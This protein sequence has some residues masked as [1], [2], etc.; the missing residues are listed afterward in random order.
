[1]IAYN[2]PSLCIVA[3]LLLRPLLGLLLLIL[4]GCRHEVFCVGNALHPHL[5]RNVKNLLA[6]FGFL[7]REFEVGIGDPWCGQIGKFLAVFLIDNPHAVQLAEMFLHFYVSFEDLLLGVEP[8]GS[9]EDLPRLLKVIAPETE[10]GVKDP[11]FAKS[12]LLMRH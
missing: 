9:A 11:Q 3:L 8:Y 12:E 1:M 4:H 7:E 5:L 6:S 10:V 2:K